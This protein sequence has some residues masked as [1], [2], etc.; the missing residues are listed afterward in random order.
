[1]LT[2]VC[3]FGWLIMVILGS[4]LVF[5]SFY[6]FSFRTDLDFL[7]VKERMLDNQIWRSM[8]YI[9]IAG[10]IVALGIGPFL[11]PER[12]IDRYSSLHK[13]LGKI[14]IIAIVL[15]SGP[16]GLYMS[17]YAEGGPFTALG[18]I[19]MSIAWVFTTSRAFIKIKEGKVQ[20]HY[21]WMIRSFAVTF[22][23]VT[24]RL[25]V[26]ILSHGFDVEQYTT[27]IATS[28]LCWAG[29]LLVAEA[30]IYWFVQDITPKNKPLDL[31]VPLDT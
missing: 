14:Y 3:R 11:F 12:L 15:V 17:F 13:T 2:Q 24:L 20:E 29:N 22:A 16:T 28:Y 21:E 26:P 6:Y 30:Y 9:H 23:G 5:T 10:G 18:F 8:F 27:W 25:W 7:E 4:W 31:E 19:L 1:M